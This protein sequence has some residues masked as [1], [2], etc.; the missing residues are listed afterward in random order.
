[1][2]R[3]LVALEGSPVA[4][5]QVANMLLDEW[6]EV[7]LVVAYDDH[8]FG[9]TAEEMLSGVRVLFTVAA[10]N[11]M[12]FYPVCGHLVEAVSNLAT[13]LDATMI[14]VSENKGTVWNRT[15]SSR[16]YPDILRKT[17]VPV[18]VVPNLPAHPRIDLRKFRKILYATDG[19]MDSA[20]TFQFVQTLMNAL[21]YAELFSLYVTDDGV[22][23][24]APLPSEH[25]QC[26]QNRTNR[27]VRRLMKSTFSNSEVRH[28]VLTCEGP[29]I[30]AI[31]DVAVHERV[32][33]VV[34]GSHRPDSM[35]RYIVRSVGK[36]VMS[37]TQVPIVVVNHPFGRM[38]NA[39]HTQVVEQI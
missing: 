15:A 21:P 31:S 35:T 33:M 24:G 5:A 2:E 3:I 7:E 28:H 36:A 16:V 22:Y 25:Y 17:S 34:V 29:V 10:A 38:L 26:E 37:R 30:R 32:D 1:M 13:E 14:V 19:V 8:H 23:P 6:A 27:V 9:L 18:M 12:S 4:A 11:R 39:L 20:V